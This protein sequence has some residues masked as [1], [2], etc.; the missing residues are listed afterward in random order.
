MKAPSVSRRIWLIVSTVAVIGGFFA[1]YFFVY[2]EARREELEAKK[3]RALA[4]YV[5]N[6]RAAYG[7]RAKK[8]Y[9]PCL[10]APR[11]DCHTQPAELREARLKVIEPII[12]QSDF[13]ELVFEVNDK[14]ER[15]TFRNS[16]NESI[17][18]TLLKKNDVIIKR[19]AEFTVNDKDYVIFVH[20]FELDRSTWRIFGF[21]DKYQFESLVRAVDLKYV[22]VASLSLILIL[23]M[24]PLLKLLIMNESEKLHMMNVWFCGFSLV[25]GTSFLLLM[26]L[27]ASDFSVSRDSVGL[28]KSD[29]LTREGRINTLSAEVEKSFVE[30]LRSI[31]DELEESNLRY[32]TGDEP[33]DYTELCPLVP[34]DGIQFACYPY[35]N[36]MLWIRT[37]GSQDK[38][39]A[40]HDIKPGDVVNL[41]KRKY[42]S[43]ALLTDSSW[44]M[45]DSDLGTERF[46]LQSIHSYITDNHEAGF[47][48]LRVK[49][50]TARG[51]IA[52]AT[53][54]HSVMDPLL[55][56]GY[57]FVIVD[58]QGKVW[59]HSQTEKNLN[60]NFIDETGWDGKLIAAINGRSEVT[61]TLSYD[62][63]THQAHLKPIRNTPL[64]LIVLHDDDFFTTPI[65]LTVGFAFLLVALLFFLQ[66]LHQL[67]L[68]VTTYRFS[69]LKVKQFFLAWL[70]PEMEKRRLYRRAVALHVLLLVPTAC[71]ALFSKSL[72]LVIF[73]L[74]LPV[75]LTV[76]HYFSTEYEEIC[77]EK[78]SYG[79]KLWTH[80]FFLASL[81]LIVY[82]NLSGVYLLGLDRLK[83]AF[84]GQLF[85]VIILS[86]FYRW[87]VLEGRAYPMM[88]MTEFTMHVTRAIVF[89]NFNAPRFHWLTKS[90]VRSYY[91]YLFLWL[92]LASI[93]PTYYFYK[94]G[95][96]EEGKMWMRYLQLTAARQQELRD[97]ELNSELL[98]V[99]GARV[100]EISEK[101]NFLNATMEILP[102][103]CD[104]CL[105]CDSASQ[106][107]HKLIFRVVPPLSG[108]AEQSR[109]AIFPCAG[110]EMWISKGNDLS[111]ELHYYTGQREQRFYR[112]ELPKYQALKGD[113]APLFLVIAVL[114]AL[115]VYRTLRF[116]ITHIFGVGLI[117]G[118]RY[119]TPKLSPGVRYF[120][121]GLPH[122]GKSTL[123][124]RIRRKEKILKSDVIIVKL[125]DSTPVV[126]TS[127]CKLIIAKG[128]HLDLNN[129]VS[130]QNKL[131]RM[132]ILFN[133]KSVPVIVISDI[134]PS[135]ILEF[136]DK[137]ADYYRHEKEDC[138]LDG[139]FRECKQAYLNWSNIL[140]SYSIHYH[141]LKECRRFEE[142]NINSELGHGE[143]LPRLYH[144]LNTPIVTLQEHEKMVLQVENLCQT[145]YRA[146]WN[147]LATSEKFLLHDLA[148][149]RFVNMRNL[150]SIR[151]LRQK[152]L[153]VGRNSLQIMNKSFNNFILSI[154]NDDADIK[155]EQQIRQKGSWNTVHL[156]LVIAIISIIVFLGLAQQELFRNFQAILAA[157]AALLPLLAR[158]GGIFTGTKE[159]E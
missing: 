30:E 22:V 59:F 145:Y 98:E 44:T 105:S 140:T 24:M 49:S 151:A 141:K 104:A 53:K 129:H 28:E 148:K 33:R 153:M 134:D 124:K 123:V 73:F 133:Y 78:I 8:L 25:V 84:F 80:P 125:N 114:G 11:K 131:N 149:D 156:I 81:L 6:I 143:F 155:M 1:Y 152:G 38:L 19:K 37:D 17:V 106:S 34:R 46:A 103:G 77:R 111:S 130:N 116:C 4:Q 75:Y 62:H 115:L 117:R 118:D 14:I 120:I 2:M 74:L 39:M 119:K 94:I 146:I 144:Q 85:V 90:Y 107:I 54:L 26:V 23:L 5:D 97:V 147:C 121:V 47:G 127:N 69:L 56:P 40:T 93:I 64:T 95:Y 113:Y 135:A 45:P 157:T 13:S 10:R 32:G 41:K 60:E 36:E 43:R 82:V 16:I 138:G 150:K 128:F 83:V 159:K 108:I 66:G 136:Y 35:F 76:Y 57:R 154:A 55:P 137:L 68:F 102:E 88:S 126:I 58:Q 51:V 52:M 72:D 7:E 158:F 65:V 132:E 21:C 3:F 31:Y 15:Q 27:M 142:K 71:V 70:R 86:S 29:S 63:S 96:Y 87:R 92:I 67:I 12:G 100:K 79:R 110:D 101:G 91:N 20:S 48:I 122:S 109:A 99:F 61:L 9:E 139:K 18:D 112:T 42:F 50:D 89:P